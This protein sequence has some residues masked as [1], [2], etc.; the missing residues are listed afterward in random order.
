LIIPF[1]DAFLT[2]LEVFDLDPKTGGSFPPCD[3]RE[4]LYS[5][6]L[7]SGFDFLQDFFRGAMAFPIRI[8]Q[9]SGEAQIDV[10]S[11]HTRGFLPHRSATL[12]AE[13]AAVLKTSRKSV[14]LDQ[15]EA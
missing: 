1:S 13:E 10:F 7:P 12:S 11:V 2:L 8:R 5:V 14:R 15:E 3:S 9:A 4:S 6:A